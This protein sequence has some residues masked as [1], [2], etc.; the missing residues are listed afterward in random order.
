MHLIKTN[1]YLLIAIFTVLYMAFIV[2]KTA[3]RQLD[4]Y[5]L[6]ML[7]AVAIIPGAFV[8][9]PGLA[10]W[11]AGLVGVEFPFVL[12]FGMLFVVLFVFIHRLTVKIH[13]LESDNRMLV[14]ELG[15]LRYAIR[16]GG[17]GVTVE[18]STT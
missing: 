9:F 14:Q 13:R 1:T 6:F 15:L 18:K 10:F 2:R 4:L 5:D 11:L 16:G 12:M 3:R 17:R 8:A 7:S